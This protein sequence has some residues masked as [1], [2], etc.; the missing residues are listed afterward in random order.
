MEDVRSEAGNEALHA[1]VIDDAAAAGQGAIEVLDYAPRPTNALL[2][3]PVGAALLWLALPVLGEQTLQMLV[4]LVDMALAGTVGKE[5]SAAVGL[6]SYVNWLANLLFA[7]IGA[8]ATALVSR[9]V[10]MGRPDQ[11]NHFSNQALAVATF[12]GMLVYALIA[13]CAP[14]LT[15]VLGWEPEPARLA[16]QFLRINAAGQIVASLTIIAG[17]CWRGM[18][19]TRTSLYVMCVINVVNMTVATALC[20]GWGPI[21]AIGVPGIAIGAMTAQITGGAVVVWLLIRGRSG[22][23]L[24]RHELRFRTDSLKRILRVGVPAGLDGLFL[25]LGQFVF[26]MIISRLATGADQAATVAAHF[27]GIRAESLS[28]LPAFAWATAAATLVGQ[29]LGAG[30]AARARRSGHLAAMQ[31]AGLCAFMGVIYFVFA[32]PIYALFNSSDDLTRVA[33][34]GV[35]ALRGLAL[36]QIPLAFMIV[37]TIALRGAG[38]TRYPLLFTLIGMVGFRLPLA[39]VC[40]IVLKGGLVGAWIGMYADMTV[41]ASLTTWR[42]MRGKWV[43][44]KV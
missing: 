31:S 22:I 11:S 3:R 14:A 26:L 35:P 20:F 4:G 33:S 34:I 18:G 28:Y 1:E 27:V 2:T 5:A 39:Y 8:G 40:G 41:R 9:H 15:R 30:D 21:P 7:F 29:S 23:R 17:A 38:D 43:H 32:H 36:F 16:V 42:F 37:Y 12:L 19:D 25:W 44:V 6:A 10:G 13:V 24:R